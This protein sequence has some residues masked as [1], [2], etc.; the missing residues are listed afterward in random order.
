LPSGALLTFSQV[1]TGSRRALSCLRQRASEGS[2]KKAYLP[3]SANGVQLE[4]SS[5]LC[6]GHQ[7][8]GQPAA[9]S[10]MWLTYFFSFLFPCASSCG[11]K[12]LGAVRSVAVPRPF[13][14]LQKPFLSPVEAGHPRY[15]KA[16]MCEYMLSSPSLSVVL[17]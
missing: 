1:Q 15:V 13:N 2:G 5:Q 8:T 7:P 12:T 14:V 16:Y 10:N 6:S 17:E 11:K 9:H 3:E 4:V